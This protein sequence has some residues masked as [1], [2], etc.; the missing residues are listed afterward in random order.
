MSTA[1]PILDPPTF[2][3]VR[4]LVLEHSAIAL[5]PTKDYLVESRLAPLARQNG[6]A[7]LGDLVARLRGQPYG[8]LHA[9]VVE[10]MTTNETSFFRDI[11]PFEA[12]KKDVLPQLVAARSHCKSL[13]IWSAACSTGQEA[14]SLAILLAEH[15]PQLADWNVQIIASDLSQQVLERARAA[16]YTQLEVNRGL[17]ASL[18]V[19][20][21]EQDG[22]RWRV[23]PE[24]RRRVRFL[25]LNL[26]QPW[27]YLPTF[28]VV[29][30]RNVLIYFTPETKR[31]LLRQLQ[32]RMAGDGVLF[33]GGAE[34]TLGIDDSWERVCHG[35]ASSY[36]LAPA[37][38]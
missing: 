24:I 15:F 21:F 12:L 8:E 29:F 9:A 13:N 25:R 23:K 7:S 37:R 19:K 2:E 4:K 26:I 18:L 20:H 27:P 10:A 17:A 35:K 28:D 3:Y 34:T 38:T 31:Q 16:E 30:L 36:R 14:Y 1:A 33:L 11:H 32:R 5:E 6:L 22:L